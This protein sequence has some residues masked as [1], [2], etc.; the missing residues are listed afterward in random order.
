M[1]GEQNTFKFRAHFCRFLVHPYLIALFQAGDQFC[2]PIR[3]WRYPL[4]LWMARCAILFQC[5]PKNYSLRPMNDK[6]F[7]ISAFFHIRTGNHIRKIIGGNEVVRLKL[8]S[9]HVCAISF[10]KS[11]QRF[12][13][14]GVTDAALFDDMLG[15]WKLCVIIRNRS[16]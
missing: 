2:E 13:E 8:P 10:H 12:H 11:A 6:P 9:K 16:A 3:D 1:T 15:L 7:A 14:N 5:I 4:D